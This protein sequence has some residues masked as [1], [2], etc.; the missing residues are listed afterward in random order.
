M[1]QAAV[2]KI[3]RLMS[4]F[5]CALNDDK[6][7]CNLQPGHAALNAYIHL[8]FHRYHFLKRSRQAYFTCEKKK[9]NIFRIYSILLMYRVRSRF[10]EI[11][12]FWQIP[13]FFNSMKRS[14]SEKNFNESFWTTVHKSADR[15][16]IYPFRLVEK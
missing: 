6:I 2:Y 3:S 15:I 8:S 7:L 16:A 13:F 5:S 14:F 9:K 1:S 12:P 10:H 11:F 4:S